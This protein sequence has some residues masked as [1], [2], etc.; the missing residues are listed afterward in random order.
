MRTTATATRCPDCRAIVIAAISTDALETLCDVIPLT[1]TGEIHANLAGRRTMR[2]D[3][4][5]RLWTTGASRIPTEPMPG[6]VILAVHICGRPIPAA[7]IQPLLQPSEPT[8]DTEV[9]F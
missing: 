8:T 4:D 1:R 5:R 6:D 9:P 2:L 7:W 3:T